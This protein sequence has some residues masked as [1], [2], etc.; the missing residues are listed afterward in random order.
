MRNVVLT[1][2]Q[3]TPFDVMAI[4]KGEATVSIADAALERVRAAR[5]TV[6]GILDRGETVYGINTGFGA[7]VNTTI[8]SSDLE[9]LQVNLLR[10]HATA[11]GEPLSESRTRAMMTVRLN[12]LVKGHSGVHEDPLHLLVDLLN[13]GITPYVPH[14]GSLGASGDLAPLAHMALVLIGEGLVWSESKAVPSL[15]V[16]REAGLNPI[17]L[18]AKDGLSLINGTSL[19]AALLAEASVMLQRLVPMADLVLCASLESRRCSVR[20]FDPRIH[21]VRPHPGQ[22]IVANRVTQ[23]MQGSPNVADHA[24][25]DR[26]QDPY[27]FRCAA[28]VHGVT[29]ERLEALQKTI[30][31]ELNAVTDNPLVFPDPSNPGPHEVISQGNFHGEVLGQTADS[32][33]LA[34]FEHAS[35]SER[36]M[37]QILDPARSG[38][39]PFLART[40]GLESGL[41]IVHYVAGAALA[42]MHGGI[43][44]RSGFSTVTS[45]GQEDHVS[46]GA[47]ACFNLLRVIDRFADVLSCEA[48]IAC[49]AIEG[50]PV[51]PSDAVRTLHQ[52]VR[53][54]VPALLEDRST[55]TDLEAIREALLSG[56]WLAVVDSLHPVA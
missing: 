8:G 4:A 44:P 20:P 30:A 3:L 56:S 15:N 45:G 21:D 43:L 33:A 39:R 40:S 16:L 47:T 41:M 32:T 2:S 28:Q 26:V 9:R 22:R 24:D 52:L 37:D 50:L 54:V 18:R 1:G 12:S 49:E 55:T 6:D 7:L 17:H 35:I 29:V 31:V 42:E 53:S 48:L 11:L 23:W 38:G 14:L 10:S 46:M 51:Q 27:S 19:M 36:R 34:L 13:H 25:C 5:R